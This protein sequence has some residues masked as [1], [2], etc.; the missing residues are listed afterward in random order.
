MPSLQKRLKRLQRRA[1]EARGKTAPLGPDVDVEGIREAGDKG[2]AVAGRM[3]GEARESALGAG[4]DLSAGRQAG[5]YLQV[6][7]SVLCRRVE[8]NFGGRVE[9]LP[10]AEALEEK[11]GLSDYW[12]RLVEPDADKY[13]ARVMLGPPRGY[14]IRILPGEEIELPI[15][16]CLLMEREGSLQAVHNIIIAE[17][18]SSAR[19]VTGCAA[20]GGTAAGVHLGVSEFY[21]K[22][23]ASLTFT[24]VH[25]WGEGFHVRPRSAAAVEE[26][27]SFVSNYVLLRPLLSLQAFPLTHLMGKGA[28]GRFQAVLLGK[29]GSAIDI[30]STTILS[31]EGSSA[32][33]VSRAIAADR[34]HIW[35]RGRLVAR[36]DDCRGHLDCRGMI[37][38]GKAAIEAV[39]ELCAFGVPRAELSHEAAI[40]PIAEEEVAYL[41]SRGLSRTEAVSIIVRGF[42]DAGFA[43]LPPLLQG[44]LE[45][46]CP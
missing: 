34:S 15:Q 14:F 22:K 36:T 37:S 9:I 43:G 6:D 19:L 23:G 29:G 45:K 11:G 25:S 18:G 5:A 38:S 16:S 30:G 41:M 39:P 4:V 35:A 26:G 8:E 27:A 7:G 44:E 1:E 40:S 13:T 31:G 12:W 32:E 17:E 28:R 42:L 3:G 33:A 46:V 2:R 21:V 20:Q 24:M 10:I